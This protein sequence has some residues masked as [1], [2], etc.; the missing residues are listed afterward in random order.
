MNKETWI[1][2]AIF[3]CDDCGEE[4]GD[5]IT[6]QRKAREHAKKYAHDVSGEVTRVVTYAGKTLRK[7]SDNDG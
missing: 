1:I 3:R 7:G 4:W 5:Y 6:S 2:G